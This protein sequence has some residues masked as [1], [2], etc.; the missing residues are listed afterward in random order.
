[1]HPRNKYYHVVTRSRYDAMIQ[2][3][4]IL[5][6]QYFFGRWI[7]DL[8]LVDNSSSKIVLMWTLCVWNSDKDEIHVKTKITN[9]LYGEP[10]LT[11]SVYSSGQ[12]VQIYI[13]YMIFLDLCFIDG[14]CYL[15][16]QTKIGSACYI[17]EPN[18]SRN[19]WTFING[20][21]STRQTFYKSLMLIIT[22]P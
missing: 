17:C 15:P 8:S 20:M 19:A 11:E 12:R 18:T 16:D 3:V 14:I 7:Y 9:K 5:I 1:M 6:I 22:I 10:G 4:L 13:V 2:I 21:Y